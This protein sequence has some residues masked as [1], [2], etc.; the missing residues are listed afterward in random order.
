MKR[1]FAA[2]GLVTALLSF[3]AIASAG[4][5]NQSLVTS[6]ISAAIASDAQP[7]SL[8]PTLASVASPTGAYNAQGASLAAKCSP[9]IVPAYITKPIPC[10]FGAAAGPV[11]VLWGDSNAAA[12]IPALSY[13]A[14]AE[15]ARL[16]V[17]VYPGC[18]SLFVGGIES[19]AA[20]TPTKC[21]SFHK[22]LPAAVK[23]VNPTVVISATIGMGFS[24]KQADVAGFAANW[25]S[26]FATITA[27]KTSIKRVL[28]GTTPN[29]GGQNIAACLAAAS[30]KKVLS[31]SPRYYSN[32]WYGTNYWVYLQRDV[33]SATA[34]NATLIP[35]Q[36]LF[37][38]TVSASPNYCPVVVGKYLVTVDADHISTAYMNYIS[39]ALLEMMKAAGL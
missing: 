18:S 19:G 29:R 2:L 14:K 36:S 30:P 8:T 4:T 15:K 22:A 34:S 27:S 32:S 16:A 12:W 31:C 26:T 21:T 20:V 10:W 9:A 5:T 25:K 35:V 33:A 11:W 37:C 39:P 23:A 38:D 3:G 24:G 28:M 1:S 6:A 17:F 7:A 13:V